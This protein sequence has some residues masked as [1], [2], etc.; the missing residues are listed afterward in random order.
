MNGNTHQGAT[1]MR[2]YPQS[3]LV[4]GVAFPNI[5]AM[6]TGVYQVTR[7]GDIVT[8]HYTDGSTESCVWPSVGELSKR[9]AFD[10][11]GEIQRRAR[12]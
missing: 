10:L 5:T 11:V 4:H 6:M 3:E 1:N 7:K 9:T 8:A 2:T 12:S